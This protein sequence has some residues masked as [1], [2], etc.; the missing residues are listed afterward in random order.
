MLRLK[1]SN[2][3]VGCWCKDPSSHF[4]CAS[5]F[6]RPCTRTYLRLLGPCFKTG[7][8]EPFHHT[9]VQRGRPH[10]Q[11]QHASSSSGTW[12]SWMDS[13]TPIYSLSHYGWL[14]RQ[15]PFR[16]NRCLSWNSNN[17][18]FTLLPNNLAKT[19]LVPSASLP[20]ISDTLTLFSKFFSS[21]PYG[22]CAL[23]VSNL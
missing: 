4:H 3:K 2:K 9:I 10:E 21:F 7:R 19:H 22:T 11:L 5:R 13:I 12:G 18:S 16:Y 23:S 14:A 17:Q 8:K 1:P 6:N 20:A 15:E